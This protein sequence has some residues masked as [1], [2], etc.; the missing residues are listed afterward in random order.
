M[1]NSDSKTKYGS[2]LM[3]DMMR[4][5]DIKYAAMNPGSTYRG[6]HDSIVNNL[7]NTNPEVILCTHEEIAVSVAH[8]YGKAAGKPMAAIVHN[9]VGLLH[10]TMAI[11]NAWLDEAPIIVLGGTGPMDISK[12]RPWIDW[13]HTALVQGNAVR[14]YVKWDD[15]PSHL[16][17][18]ADS[19]IRAYQIAT[20]EPKGP[21]YICLDSGLQEEE[22]TDKLLIPS[23]ERYPNPSSPQV[24]TE[25]VKRVAKLLVEA[26]NPV[27]MANF[28]GRNPESVAS[29]VS[30]AELLALPVIDVGER[31]NFPSTHPLDLTGAESELLKEA[32]VILGLDVS[33]LARYLS[34]S[35]YETRLSKSLIPE[36]CQ[37]VNFSL[38]HLGIKSWSS[39]YG[40][41]V[42]TDI[43]IAADTSLALPL[44]TAACRELLTDKR[45]AA[46]QERFNNL[47]ARHKALRKQWQ[48]TAENEQDK[49]PISLS[50][51]ARQMWEV[52]K[53]EDWALV[54]GDFGGWA[55]RLWDWERP[56]QYNGTAGLGCGPGHSL[57]GALAHQPEGRLCID[58]QPDGDFLY[59]PGALWTAA[60][61]QIPM[62]VIM[63]NNRTYYNSE[64]HQEI[65][66][67]TRG[68][69]VENRS[70]GIHIDNPHVD[71]AGLARSLGVHGVGPIENP[72]DLPSA[73]EEA[74]KVV[75]DKKQ[76]ALVDIVTPRGR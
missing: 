39:S 59:T 3:A 7:G 5:L 36:E 6:L 53:D 14:D 60:H 66:A 63:N 30:L 57:G 75:R 52:I 15:Q 28:M 13:I 12:R 67:T 35:D 17:G 58:F 24:D 21:V 33:N 56:Y 48:T 44:L 51:L 18:V 10:G 50:W 69:P 9:V 37:I 72:K 23:M 64:R 40:K 46:F 76:P 27:V 61:H 25:T 41:L 22:L 19:F 20:T 47:K 2:D 49:S 42:P 68:R 31:F 34:S 1:T 74:V 4:T 29:L 73:L 38:R 11:Y 71:Y 54:S 45:R 65:M 43:P 16:T 26:A 8:G 55:R 32:D 70:I 62:L